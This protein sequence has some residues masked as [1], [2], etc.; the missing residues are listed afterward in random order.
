[1]KTINIT[2]LKTGGY[3]TSGRGGAGGG[4]GGG[5]IRS[6]ELYRPEGNGQQVE[7]IYKTNKK[8]NN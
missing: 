8:K 1:M 4:D 6:T 2:S 3:F 5:V 7:F